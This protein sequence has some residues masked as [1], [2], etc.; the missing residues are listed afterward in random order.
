MEVG[1]LPPKAEICNIDSER[2][3]RGE[4]VENRLMFFLANYPVSTMPEMMCCPF[5][6]LWRQWLELDNRGGFSVIIGLERNL[7]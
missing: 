7:L 4:G 5:R 1:Y 2:Y 6:M 3:L